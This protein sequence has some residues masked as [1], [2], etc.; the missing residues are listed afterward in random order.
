M[1]ELLCITTRFFFLRCLV[2]SE[3]LVLREGLVV[4]EDL[5]PPSSG[6][7]AGRTEAEGNGQRGQIVVSKPIL[8][9]FFLR[10]D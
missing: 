6:T 4:G 10:S 8:I 1:N 9:I 2:E 5:G 3:G 7:M